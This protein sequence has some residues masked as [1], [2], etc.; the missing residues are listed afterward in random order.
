MLLGQG[1]FIQHLLE[2]ISADLNKPSHSIVRHNLLG[3]LESAI[4]SSNAQYD[5]ADVTSRLD[6]R[7]STEVELSS[8][9]HSHHQQA[10]NNIGWDMFTLYYVVNSPLDTI[11][12]EDAL[13]VYQRIFKHLWKL[14]RVDAMLDT[15]W[16]KHQE[17][18][19][20]FAQNRKNILYNRFASILHKC[21]LLR[22]EVHFSYISYLFRWC[23]SVTIFNTILCLR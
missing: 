12:S 6:I 11:F 9:E 7:L 22:H 15:T 17:L 16:M 21:N 3:I 23:I 2:L 19:R 14:K 10:A 5:D 20:A 8:D 1:D 18:A 13:R 4:R